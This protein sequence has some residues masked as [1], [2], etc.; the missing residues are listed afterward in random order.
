M[1][2]TLGIS[3]FLKSSLVFPILLFSSISLHWSLRKGFLISPCYSL[4]LYIQMGISFLFSFALASLLYLTLFVRPPQTAILRFLH[5]F[6]LLGKVL[7]TASCTMSWI[8]VH[9]S[10]VTLSDLFLESICHFHCIIVRDWFRSYLNGLVVF[11]T[12]FHFSLNL[13]I[14]SSW[15][16]PQSAP[17][18][19]FADCIE[20]L[21]LWLQRI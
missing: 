15:S 10:S 20:L 1:K 11:P 13:A 16:E 19:V 12:F 7:I 21:H 5:F 18:L 2:C 9:S 14:R 17:G 8:S 3:N 4:E 6:F